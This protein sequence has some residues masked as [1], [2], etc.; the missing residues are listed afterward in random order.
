MMSGPSSSLSDEIFLGIIASIGAVLYAGFAYLVAHSNNIEVRRRWRYSILWGVTFGVFTSI[1][2]GILSVLGLLGSENELGYGAAFKSPRSLL[3][4]FIGIFSSL[5][6]PVI[7]S[8]PFVFLITVGT[9]WKQLG[10]GDYFINQ[11]LYPVKKHF[12]DQSTDSIFDRVRTFI[13]KLID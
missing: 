12:S 3:D 11:L 5:V 2:F 10:M 8:L 4:L 13:A 7:I 1:L 9:Y 6:A